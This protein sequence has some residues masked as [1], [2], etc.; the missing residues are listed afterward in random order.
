MVNAQS[1]VRDSFF[2]SAATGEDADIGE[3]L[4]RAGLIQSRSTDGIENAFGGEVV[5]QRR[6]EERGFE[7]I[8]RE[9]PVGACVQLAPFESNG[10]GTVGVGITG[11]IIND[12]FVEGSE[13][14]VSVAEG[15]SLC[16]EGRTGFLAAAG[17]VDVGW[18]FSDGL[19]AVV[20]SDS[21]G[22]GSGGSGGDTGGGSGIGD[23]DLPGDPGD[24]GTPGD[25]SGGD[26]GDG[27]GDDGNGDDGNGDTG[28]DPEPTPPEQTDHSFPTANVAPDDDPLATTEVSAGDAVT[29]DWIQE[30]TQMTLSGSGNPQVCVV[31]GGVCS[32]TDGPVTVEP[33]DDVRFRVDTPDNSGEYNQAI[34]EI[35]GETLGFVAQS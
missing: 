12:D 6:Q 28:G 7:I 34:G 22:G 25:G 21:G 26:G 5:I 10:Q 29:V 23:D 24:G 2:R 3:Y 14:G 11:L 13:N 1:A 16:S 8:L 27:N 33:G 18:R 19:D 35:G 15:G 9:I 30:P 17:T 31:S 20:A 4:Q 32:F